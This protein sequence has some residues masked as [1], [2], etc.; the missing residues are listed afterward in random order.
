[1]KGK[2]LILIGLIALAVGLLLILFRNTL[3]N[4]GIVLAG[5]VLFLVAGVLNMTVFLG[6]RDDKGKAKMGA[7]G[8]TFG[9]V[10]SAAAVVLGL[11]MIIFKGAFVALISFMFGVL[12]LFAALFQI[13]LLIFG[14]RPVHISNWFFLVPTVIVGGAIY[15][16]LHNHDASG[17]ITDLIVTGSIFILFGVFTIIEGSA[18]GQANRMLRASAETKEPERLEEAKT[19]DSESA[20]KPEAKTE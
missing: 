12:I 17:E 6:S 11:S 7:F 1:M 18:I 9:W 20:D 13:F 8:T 4:G 2:N 5:G 15:L 10:A 16:F 3:A 14:T 19:A